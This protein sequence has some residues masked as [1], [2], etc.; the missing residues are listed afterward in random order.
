MHRYVIL[1]EIFACLL[2]PNQQQLPGADSVFYCSPMDRF[3][4]LD[5]YPLANTTTCSAL[6]NKVRI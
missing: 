4:A 3:L 2:I 1:T 6:I 5:P